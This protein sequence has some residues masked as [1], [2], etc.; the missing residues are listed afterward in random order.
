[1]FT[2]TT[3]IVYLLL[4]LLMV[5]TMANAGGVAPGEETPKTQVVREKVAATP[6]QT[7]AAVSTARRAVTPRLES[8]PAVKEV[9][10]PSV[11]PKAVVSANKDSWLLSPREGECA[12]LS[13][14]SKKVKNI[15]TFK[16]PQ[17]FARKLQQRGY[18]A[19]ALDIGDVRGQ[20]VRVKVPDLDLDL[21]F[22]KAGMC[23]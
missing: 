18:Q 20:E 23:R 19:F 15:G 17:E 22:V 2:K 3:K 5:A 10:V 9:P 6:A 12:P 11:R 4:S 16:T 21:T 8:A 14:V 1:M 13:S 7:S